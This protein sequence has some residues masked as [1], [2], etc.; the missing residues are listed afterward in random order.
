MK[1]CEQKE[2]EEGEDRKSRIRENRR[3]SRRI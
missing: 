2:R 1:K 3:E